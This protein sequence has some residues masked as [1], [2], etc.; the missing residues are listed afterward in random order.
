M[1]TNLPKCETYL[2]QR[3]LMRGVSKGCSAFQKWDTGN[4][5]YNFKELL[6]CHP[7]VESAR[8]GQCHESNFGL[9]GELID[10]GA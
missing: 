5:T 1:P 8:V 4:Y 7:R 3:V 10:K 6:T 9:S 2:V